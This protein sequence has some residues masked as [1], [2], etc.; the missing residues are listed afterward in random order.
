M[1]GLLLGILALPLACAKG[2]PELGP[3]ESPS[4][5]VDA[6]RMR[7]QWQDV[8]LFRASVEAASSGVDQEIALGIETPVPRDYSGGYTHERHKK[9]YMIAARA[10][11]L[12]EILGEERYAVYVRDM[13]LQ[14]ARM[15]RGLPLHPKTRSYARGKIFWQCLNDANWLAFMSQA[16][17]AVRSFLSTAERTQIEE[18]LLRPFAD[19]ISIASPQFFNRI[20]NH[21]TWGTAAVGILGLVLGDDGLVQR[22]LY[23]LELENDGDARDDDG[24]FLRRAGDPKGFFANLD[25][26]FSPDGYY[27]EGPYYQRYALYPFLLFAQS[28][29]AAA[30]REQAFPRRDGVLLKAV[31]TLLQLSNSRGEFFALNDAQKGMSIRA[32]SVVYAVNS[33]F[34][35]SGDTSLLGI[36]VEQDRVSLDLAGFLVAEAIANRGRKPF[37]KGTVHLSDGPLGAQGGLSVLRDDPLTIVFKYTAQGLGHGHYDKL[38]Y[39]LHRNGQE[40][41]QD[42]GMVRYVNVEPKGGGNY[43]PENSTWAKQSIAHNTLIV[44]ETSHF[45]GLYETASRFHS[46]RVFVGAQESPHRVQV[47]V[48]QDSNAYPGLMLRR[49]LALLELPGASDPLVL[50]VFEVQSR[51][52]DERQLDLPFH[53]FGQPIDVNAELTEVSSRSPL[54][55]AH[56]YQHSILEAEGAAAEGA[57]RFSWLDRQRFFTLTAL[58][59]PGDRVLLG[60]LGA[61]DPEFNLRRDPHVVF[62]RVAAGDTVFVTAL[63]SH[64]RYDPAFEKAFGATGVLE[65][66]TVPVDDERYRAIVLW[67]RGHAPMIF[68]WAKSAGAGTEHRVRIN[69]REIRWTGRFAYTR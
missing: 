58:S 21:S 51:D 15:Y 22:A 9:N 6:A 31:H 3:K 26:A 44:D 45:G 5:L 62:R 34:Q 18:Q 38:S 29:R 46:E 10:A 1:K 33:A 56:G 60:R 64:G 50:D 53:Y 52:G 30:Y 36:A 37:R 42:Y 17:A 59:H 66:L 47:A 48:A 65:S 39:S 11:A 54:G 7:A 69:G 4:E 13:L 23:G 57:T 55:A 68:I 28:L 63:E 61:K 49:L 19:H 32:E 16:Y 27:T 14:Y 35:V 12:Y 2:A 67:L 40:V 24:G 43:L 41:L 25:T 8:P 20:H